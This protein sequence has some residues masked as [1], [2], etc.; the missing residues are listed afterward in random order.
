ME[1]SDITKADLKQVLNME[2]IYFPFEF[3]NRRMMVDMM[4]D[5][6]YV[7]KVLKED[8]IICAYIIIYKNVDYDEVFK[9]AVN[10]PHKRTGLGT[11]LI[12]Y[13]KEQ[14]TN[15][16]CLEVRSKNLGAVNFYLNNGFYVVGIRKDYYLGGNNAILM[17]Y[18]K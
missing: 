7:I 6:K 11:K 1:M 5:E 16:L 3:F 13:A 15:K 10:D 4:K 17:E 9:I 14:C 2:L 12:D 8:D 18:I